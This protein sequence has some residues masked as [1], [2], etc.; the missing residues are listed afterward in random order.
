LILGESI[1][2]LLLYPVTLLFNNVN[3]LLAYGM[4]KVVQFFALLP[5][6]HFF[7]A[8]PPSFPECRVTVL[9][10]EP[11][12]AIVIQSRTSV[13]LVD[14]G[15]ES[16]YFRVVRPFLQSRGVNHLSGLIITHNGV[17]SGGAL[18]DVVSDFAPQKI[19]GPSATALKP[20]DQVRLGANV[21]CTVLFPPSGY[22]S[23]ISADKSL[24]LRLEDGRT[25]VLLMSECGFGGEHWLLEHPGDLR[26]SVVVVGGQSADLAGTDE[27]IG[28]VKPIAVIRGAPG[29]GGSPIEE[30]RWAGRLNQ[31][32]AKPYLQS[33]HGAV[34]IEVTQSN[35][36]IIPFLDT[37]IPRD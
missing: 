12:Q 16:A 21:N 4:L 2:S 33:Q 32:G 25:R 28:A 9:D 11:G 14:C 8:V 3:W 10:L 27:F 18:Q 24:V 37:G 22:W 7:V 23:G 35:A 26:A 6:G 30:R 34:T 1:F 15:N 31:L 36:Q 19:Y 29:Y 13:W 5:G 17:R 20:G